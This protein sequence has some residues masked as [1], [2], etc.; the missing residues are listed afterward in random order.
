M[1]LSVTPS[2]NAFMRRFP[3]IQAT[4]MAKPPAGAGS[5]PS[6]LPMIC[7]DGPL[8]HDDLECEFCEKRVTTFSQ[9]SRSMRA[10]SFGR[11]LVCRARQPPAPVITLR[12]AKSAPSRTAPKPFARKGE[13]LQDMLFVWRIPRSK[14]QASSGNRF[15][16]FDGQTVEAITMRHHNREQR[17]EFVRW[18]AALTPIDPSPAAS[19]RGPLRRSEKNVKPSLSQPLWNL[20]LHRK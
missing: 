6:S 17:A 1:L 10:G 11:D 14:D 13:G 9:K 20:S 2:A 3:P 5:R 12:P 16:Q 19:T 7:F 18:P 8:D 4:R 15:G